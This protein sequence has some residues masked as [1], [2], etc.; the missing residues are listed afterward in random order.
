MIISNCCISSAGRVPVSTSRSAGET[1]LLDRPSSSFPDL[2]KHKLG[3]HEGEGDDDHTHTTIQSHLSD[4]HPQQQQQQQNHHDDDDD[5]AYRPRVV[6]VTRLALTNENERLGDEG[7]SEK[8]RPSSST[9]RSN[10]EQEPTEM[11][12]ELSCHSD[13]T[14]SNSNSS[15]V[16]LSLESSGGDDDDDM[17]WIGGEEAGDSVATVIAANS[18][19]RSPSHEYEIDSTFLSM[20]RHEGKDDTDLLYSQCDGHPKD[21]NS[22]VVSILKSAYR[23][24]P[25]HIRNTRR[26]WKCLPPPDLEKIYSSVSKKRADSQT[27]DHDDR[28]TATATTTTTV[29]TI[30][31]S[32]TTTTTTM[33][34]T[35]SH[36]EKKN[37]CFTAIQIRSYHQTLGDNPSVSYGPPISLDWTYEQEVIEQSIDVYEQTRRP[38]RSQRQMAMSYYQRQNLLSWMYGIPKDELRRAKKEANKIK[39]NRSITNT[40]LPIMAVESVIE[41][42][43]RKAKK[44][45]RSASSPT[46]DSSQGVATS[47]DR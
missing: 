15:P 21:R 17:D 47:E 8:D 1:P 9:E 46:Y 42:A 37:V 31:S 2:N 25:F 18:G 28:T 27:M 22:R 13:S 10:V 30:T 26:S 5:D 41:S 33:A 36:S 12:E 45:V 39:L 38:R 34:K 24:E 11:N 32:T 43:Q 35:K 6:S 4:P 7:H 16:G 3:Q 20:A 44:L 40:F 23:S 19:N 29:A 14:A